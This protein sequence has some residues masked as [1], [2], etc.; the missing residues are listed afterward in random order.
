MKTTE[1][2]S[3]ASAL[4]ER[5]LSQATANH[6]VVMLNDAKRL[7][8]DNINNALTPPERSRASSVG[9]ARAGFVRKVVEIWRTNQQ[10][11]PGYI[12]TPE[13]IRLTKSSTATPA[14]LP[15]HKSLSPSPPMPVLYLPKSCTAFRFRSTTM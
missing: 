6:L 2:K 13:I 10:F 15:P 7:L 3:T 14:L 9:I 5:N 11:A 4:D 8:E 12:T 1:K